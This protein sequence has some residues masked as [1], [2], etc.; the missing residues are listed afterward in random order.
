MN[1]LRP[2]LLD[3]LAR[4][5]ALGTLS[6]GAARRFTRVVAGSAAAARAVADWQA[7]LQTLEEGAPASPEPRPRVWDAVQQRLFERDARAPSAVAAGGRRGAGGLAAGWLRWPVGLVAGALLSWTLLVLRPQTFGMEPLAGSA[8]AS[9]VGVL[10]DPQGH[11]LLATAARRQGD[12]LTVRLL[13]PVAIEPGR[14]LTLWAWNDADPT[15]RRVGSWTTA[16]QTST[17]TLP[18]P[19]EALLG[20]MTRL[21]LSNEAADVAPAAPTRPFVAEGACAKVW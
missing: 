10:Q 2:E 1:Y 21:G 9:Y 11:A 8:P 12:V 20:K 17:I 16:G 14:A 5:H 6:P 19:A 13:R 15:P 18:A 7:V 4:A 3:A